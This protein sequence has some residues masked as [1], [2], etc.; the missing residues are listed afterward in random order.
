MLLLNAVGLLPSVVQTRS[1]RPNQTWQTLRWGVPVPMTSSGVYVISLSENVNSCTTHFATVPVDKAALERWLIIRP[2]LRLDGQRPDIAAL[3]QRLSRFWLPDEVVL[4]IGLA[5]SLKGRIGGYY[6]TPLGARKPHAGGFFL[7]TLSNLQDLFVHYSPTAN[8]E[9][10]EQTMLEHFCHN[11][12]TDSKKTLPD[13]TCPFPF[14]NLEFPA[15]S[16]Q[17]S[18]DHW[19]ART[20]MPQ[21]I[22]TRRL[23]R[24]GD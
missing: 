11:V 3:T 16:A 2:E 9:A 17:A 10:D 20:K 21:L 4:Y 19:S 15:R 6:K 1:L 23:I 22:S 7:K 13:A 8:F 14:A 18:R 12:S 5:S 24:I